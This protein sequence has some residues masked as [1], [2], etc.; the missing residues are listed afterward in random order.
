MKL[1][2][3]KVDKKETEQIMSDWKFKNEMSR[4]II[5]H[6]LLKA[7]RRNMRK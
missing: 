7:K 4:K 5:E 3:L 2:P 1:I 6:R